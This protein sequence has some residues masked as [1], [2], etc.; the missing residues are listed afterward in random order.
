MAELLLQLALFSG[1]LF[2]FLIFILL[3]LLTIALIVSKHK[4]KSKGH[5]TIKNLSNKYAELQ[6]ALFAETLPKKKLK[7]TLKERKQKLK[8]AESEIKKNLF[9]ID[10]QGD[11]KASAVSSLREEI[12]AILSVATPQDEVI[13]RLESA[14]GIVH[15]YGLAAAE[16]IRLREQKIPLTIIIDKVAASGGYLMACV[17][18]KIIAAP[19]AIIGSIGVVVQ[20]PNFHRLLQDNHIDFELHTAGQFKRTITLFGENT[21][22]G[23]KKLQ[24]DIES[25]HQSFKDLIKQYRPH[26]DIEKIATGEYW[27][28]SKALTLNLIDELGTSDDYIF[29]ANKISKIYEIC[30]ETKKPLLTRLTASANTVQEKL[31]GLVGRTPLLKAKF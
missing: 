31:W 3:L 29:K 1:K 11:M 6:E 26:I 18:D 15:G 13:I 19:F 25:I 23:R 14:G 5:L 20:L 24:A 7:T 30:Y 27:L 22:E 4:D 12:T 28:A 10:F 21:D 8:Q 9:V 2:I 17:A 16:L